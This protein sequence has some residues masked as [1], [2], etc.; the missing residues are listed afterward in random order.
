MHAHEDAHEDA[1]MDAHE[2]AHEDAHVHSTC[3]RCMFD[4]SGEH[5]GVMEAEVVGAKLREQHAHLCRPRTRYAVGWSGGARRTAHAEGT[6][7]CAHRVRAS[8][9]VVLHCAHWMPHWDVRI[10]CC[11]SGARTRAAR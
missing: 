1:H 11:G 10:V 9:G 8:S 6:R 2:D 7:G 5:L 4:H 3:M